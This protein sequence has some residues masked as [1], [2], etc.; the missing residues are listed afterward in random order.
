MGAVQ[1]H[2]ELFVNIFSAGARGNQPS[3]WPSDPHLLLSTSCVV[4][5]HAESP[6]VVDGVWSVISSVNSEEAL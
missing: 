2:P 3:R 5:S 1:A 4:P 6:W